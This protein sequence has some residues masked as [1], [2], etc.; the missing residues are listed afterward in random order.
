MVPRTLR[1][2]FPQAIVPSQMSVLIVEGLEMV[3]IEHN[4]REGPA[5]PRRASQ[6]P[7]QE[8][9][10]IAFIVRFRQGVNNRQAINFLV[11]FRFQVAAGQEA[12]D[13][14]AHPQIVAVLQAIHGHLLVVDEGA[15]GALQIDGVIAVGAGLNPGMAARHGVIVDVDVGLGAPA[16]DQGLVAEGI[17]GPHARPGRIDEDQTGVA[18]RRLRRITHYTDPG[19]AG[20]VHPSSLLP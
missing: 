20:L 7:I 6:L 8:L 14:V 4:D 17:T 15:V 16:D 10:Q 1:R 11:V 19:F 18:V 9:Q 5:V 12:I 3:D 2:Q 13:A